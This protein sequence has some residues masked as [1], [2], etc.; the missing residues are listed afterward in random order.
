MFLR[1]LS[2]RQMLEMHFNVFRANS[3][4]CQRSKRA[5][6]CKQKNRVELIIRAL[7]QSWQLCWYLCL[8]YS[9]LH[10]LAEVGFLV[11]N[12]AVF[13]LR[14]FD[15]S[16]EI[17]FLDTNLQKDSNL[18]PHA[19]HSPFYLRI[20]KRTFLYSSILI[21]QKIRETRKLE[22]IYE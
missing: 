4:C 19:I 7:Q 14:S 5:D 9:S 22:S 10:S 12:V 20:S 3:I 15:L 13:K 8:I 18:L 17:E 11:F 21:L 1:N 6:T 16:L 2:L